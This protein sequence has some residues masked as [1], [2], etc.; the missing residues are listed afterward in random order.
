MRVAGTSCFSFA[1]S[2][3]ACLYAA[4]S[5]LRLASCLAL[6]LLLL[7]IGLGSSHATPGGEVSLGGGSGGAQ[8]DEGSEQEPAA[9]TSVAGG[10]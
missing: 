1:L 3:A 10:R 6:A 9:V 5:C 4:L 7:Y 2:F 8:T